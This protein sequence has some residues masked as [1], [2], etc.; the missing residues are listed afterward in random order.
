MRG[1]AVQPSKS[2]TKLIFVT[3]IPNAKAVAQVPAVINT[4]LVV[5]KIFKI[6]LYL[7]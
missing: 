7:N 4:C 1:F 5:P 3:N 6:I 2:T